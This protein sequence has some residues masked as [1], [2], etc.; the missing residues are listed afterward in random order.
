MLN[1]EALSQTFMPGLTDKPLVIRKS[2]QAIL[3][4]LFHEKELNRFQSNYPHLEGLDFVEQLLDH[5]DVSYSLRGN[6]RERI[7]PHGR[8]VIIANHPIGTLDAA[9]LL[10]LIGEIRRDVKAVSNQLLSGLQPLSS[11]LLPV[12]NM[13]GRSSREQLKGVYRHLENEGA[14]IIF[15]AGEVSRMSPTGIKDGHWHSGF[16]RIATATRAPILPVCIDGR[17]SMFFYTLSMLSRPLS[18]LW[19]V[20]EMFKQSSRSL[21]LSIGNPITFE[22]YQRTH[23]PLKSCAKLFQRHVYRIGKQKEPVFATLR[24]IAHPE[25]RQRL[26]R[27]IQRCT[28]LGETDDG[29]QIY[30]SDFNPDSCIMREVGRLREI[31]FRAVGEGT[32]LRRDTDPFDRHCHQLIL[33]DE[34]A[35]EI[36]GAYRLRDTCHADPASLYSNT[37][38]H[39]EAGMQ[40]II[41]NGLEL[42]RSFVQ[43]RYW[44]KRSLDYLWFGIGAFLR[45]NPH[46]RYLFGPVSISNSYPA[47]ALDMLTWYYN[48]YFGTET[49]LAYAR[50]PYTL[51]PH[52]QQQMREVFH[53]NDRKRDFVTLKSRM[54]HLGCSIPTLLKQ[55]SELCET[56]GVSMPAFNIDPDFSSCVDALVV[57]DLERL[58]PS[59]RNRYIHNDTK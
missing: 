49:A 25:D 8:V 24:A 19:L 36:V 23:L 59:K 57:L 38:F 5:F 10:R 28:L 51:L 43:P 22:N 58:K 46:Y 20:R 40:P 11:L 16:L 55:Y 4:S 18:T 13:G 47:A 45:N 29:K 27:E 3:R 2:L 9:V 32:G 41:R 7:P 26:H 54:G 12:D 17:N 44:G 34:S 37:L 31:A 56:G 6:E 30:L 35:L 42:G 39:F 14:V 53:G 15:P 21:H 1:I 33:W 52:T 50:L 48:H